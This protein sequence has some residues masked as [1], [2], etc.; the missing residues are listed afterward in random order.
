MHAGRIV[1]RVDGAV[2]AVFPPLSWDAA[3]EEDFA[4]AAN[5]QLAEPIYDIHL[6]GRANA[7]LVRSRKTVS[8]R[9]ARTGLLI[10]EFPHLAEFADCVRWL[11]GSDRFL[12]GCRDGSLRILDARDPDTVLFA[13]KAHQWNIRS[14]A[15]SRDG[16]TA[17]TGSDDRV[18]L[19]DLNRFE[20]IRQIPMHGWGP[21]VLRFSPDETRLLIA[22]E[23]GTLKIYRVPDLEL[24]RELE[25]RA[26]FIVAAAFLA[27]GREVISGDILG[28]VTIHDL[29]TGKVRWSESLC[30]LQLI[31]MEVSPDERFVVLSDWSKNVS[32][33]SLETME[34]VAE[35]PARSHAV[36]VQRFS[37][38][39][40]WLYTAGYDGIVRICDFATFAELGSFQAARPAD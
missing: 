6:N 38:D 40:N 29:A 8:V 20:M 23:Q 24:E 10:R 2:C 21:S 18:C 7:I 34:K 4:A 19:W 30:E 13:S 25:K 27:H 28:E 36:S 26:T 32:V 31:H 17:V 14:T 35:L 16:K 9:D 1:C 22:G 11:P 5:R 12:A 37:A 3:E 39:E 15:V 33:Y